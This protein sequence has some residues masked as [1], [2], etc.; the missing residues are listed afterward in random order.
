[1]ILTWRKWRALNGIGLGQRFLGDDTKTEKKRKRKQVEL[2]IFKSFC[3]KM[4]RTEE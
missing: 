1:M 3:V 2:H 4:G